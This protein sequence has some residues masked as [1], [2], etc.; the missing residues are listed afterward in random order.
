MRIAL[1]QPD[2][3]PNAAAAARLG[4]CLG[5]PLE[6]IEPCGFVFDDRR[7]RRVGL[8]YLEL[9]AL[10]RHPSWDAF[11]RWRAA[12]GGRLI[13][14]SAHAEAAHHTVAYRADDILLAGR[15]ST[16]VP[17]EVRARA[18]LCVRVPL[19]PGRRTLNVVTALAIVLGEALRQTGGFPA[20]G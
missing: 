10:T 12:A 9:A 2:I 15:E 13:L 5:V 1:Y 16:G 8:G 4:A 3:A 6:I 11:E 19:V 18:A 7:L 14:L 17:D 20:G